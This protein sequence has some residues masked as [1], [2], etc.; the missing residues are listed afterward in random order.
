MW[1]NLHICTKHPS[2]AKDL[3]QQK[4][5]STASPAS[6]PT[7]TAPDAEHGVSTITPPDAQNPVDTQTT[8]T[9]VYASRKMYGKADTKNKQ[10]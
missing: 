8:T 7:D 3:P 6:S 4:K 1:L 2:L 5:K 10:V 9:A